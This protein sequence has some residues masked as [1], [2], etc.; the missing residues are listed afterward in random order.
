MLTIFRTHTE[1][2]K[3]TGRKNRHCN[4]PIAV[5]GRLNDEIVR[6][7][8][9]VRSW[10]VA[11]KIVREWGVKRFR[12]LRSDNRRSDEAIYRGPYLVRPNPR[13]KLEV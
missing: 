10:E 1:D 4:C 11:Q 2:G 5:E 13:H 3:F 7:S 12:K 6:R 8:L 9:D